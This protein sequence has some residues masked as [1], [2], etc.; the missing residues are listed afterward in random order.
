M[1]TKQYWAIIAALF[2][3]CFTTHGYCAVDWQ[4]GPSLKTKA[5]TLDT[6]ATPD[7]KWIFVLTK[8]GLV[9]IYDAAG[10]LEE[11]IPVAPETDH[12]A[13][14]GVGTKLLLSSKRTNTVQQLDLTFVA[15]I[16]TDGDPSMGDPQAPVKVVVFSDFQCP[17]CSK[18]GILL[19][20]IL[21]HNAETVQIIYKQFPL[22]FHKE[23]TAAAIA[24]LAAQNQGKFWEMHD[25]LFQHGK[26]LSEDMIQS[27]AKEAGLDMKQF[28]KDLSDAIL[29]ERV[30]QD[31]EDGRMAGVRGTPTI[32]VNGRTLEERS[33]EGLQALVDKELART[34]NTS[35]K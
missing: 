17:Y 6:A 30:Q 24:S 8:G 22:P 20:Y 15:D 21:E 29:A 34:K 4:P 25:L 9:N 5:P 27:L 13:V 32:F 26:E 12:I 7:G 2:T 10:I 18:V 33:P 35:A 23:A 11:T 31:I 1:H 16:N 14:N 3:L 28:N 19:E